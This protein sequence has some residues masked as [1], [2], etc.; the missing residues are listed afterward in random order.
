MPLDRCPFRIT[1]LAAAFATMAC[2]QAQQAA[3][4]QEEPVK[5]AAGEKV[6]QVEVK[7]SAEAY[8]PRRDD[9]ASKIVVSNAEIVKYGDTNVLDVLKRLPGV[10]V[11]GGAVRCAASVRVT[12]SSWSTASARLQAFRWSRWRPIPSNASK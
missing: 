9:S 1:V 7:G 11:S 3:P 2:A 10:T 8:D 4:K 6:Q 12:P 5:K